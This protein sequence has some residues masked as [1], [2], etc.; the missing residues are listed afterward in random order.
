MYS[1][2]IFREI[3]SRWLKKIDEVP[4]IRHCRI[5][6]IVQNLNNFLSHENDFK[7]MVILKWQKNIYG[8]KQK[9]FKSFWLKSWEWNFCF[10]CKSW[11]NQNIWQIKWLYSDNWG[12][13]YRD[14]IPGMSRQVWS[15]SNHLI[16]ITF[17]CICNIQRRDQGKCGT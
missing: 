5:F 6:R 16:V 7:I 9:T 2:K 10:S 4:W 12:R 13:K 17:L 1:T 15:P 8:K 14:K 3:V 11:Y